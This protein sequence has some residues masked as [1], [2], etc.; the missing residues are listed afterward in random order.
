[1][2]WLGLAPVYVGAL[3][4]GGLLVTVLLYLRQWGRRRVTVAFTPLWKRVLSEAD[5]GTSQR[6]V[7]ELLSLLLQVAMI[8]LL[9]LALGRPLLGREPG[10]RAIVLDTSASML[11]Q[12]PP[13]GDR[14]SAAKQRALELID[15]LSDNDRVALITTGGEAR[16]LYAPTRDHYAVRQRI[17][18]TEGC[19]CD[20]RLREGV[21][22]ARGVVPSGQSIDVLTDGNEA[23]DPN[24][25][26]NVELFGASVGNIGITLLGARATPAAPGRYEGVLELRSF[27]AGRARAQLRL[28]I[29]GQ[30]VDLRDVRLEP[31]QRE[32]I[33]LKE[34]KATNG[35]GL[36]K[37]ELFNI[38][39]EGTLDAL[40]ED[41]RAFALLAP[42][43]ERPVRLLSPPN[44]A[45]FVREALRANPRY[46]LIEV[47]PAKGEATPTGAITVVT[48]T[49]VPN[50]PGRYL[51]LAPPP[52]TAGT[53]LENALFSDWRTDHPVLRR[54][55]LLGV[56]IRAAQIVKPPENAQIL[57]RFGEVPL[58]Y[59]RESTDRVE[60]G[61]T[62]DAE[63][64]NLPLRVAFP[65]LLYNAIDWMSGATE[66]ESQRAP[67]R[68]WR[69][70]RL[71][72]G[73]VR[74]LK[75]DGPS[76]RAEASLRGDSI[77]VDQ[78]NAAGLY[79]IEADDE[80]F[81]IATSLTS[82]HES[83]L[84]SQAKGS[85]A[86]APLARSLDLW[87]WLVYALIALLVLEWTLYHRR[88][89]S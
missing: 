6:R 66:V 19:A 34:L 85:E 35:E 15:R 62:F 8:T 16:L 23:L 61:T 49:A 18:A 48:G 47:D 41:N 73:P 32:T 71:A 21:E 17:I 28:T 5:V 76:R 10:V 68:R 70:E 75:V 29:D 7:L 45:R 3:I 77:V 53:P 89:T 56:S 88:V 58:L 36:L 54:V 60:L 50:G 30:L 11:A 51:V 87:A 9:A 20:G 86:R 67:G 65:V 84:S 40:T 43:A 13:R 81:R 27:A 72:S 33:V 69:I 57:A 14:L 74:R 59:L 44:G 22:I 2:N 37:A 63:D 78:A 80:T 38:E 31:G 55:S 26:P 83:D 52:G 64:S 4:G 25:P 12:R 24:D 46:R 82:A 39:L 42:E 79:R 1:M